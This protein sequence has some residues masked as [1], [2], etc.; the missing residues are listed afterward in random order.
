MAGFFTGMAVEYRRR[1]SLSGGVDEF[2]IDVE[3]EARRRFEEK[4]RSEFKK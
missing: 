3:H 1:D 2:I 4:Q